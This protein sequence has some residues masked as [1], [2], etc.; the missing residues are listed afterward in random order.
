MPACDAVI[1]AYSGQ[2]NHNAGSRRANH[3]WQVLAR[4]PIQIPTRVRC[5]LEVSLEGGEDGHVKWIFH[6]TGLLIF[7]S[8]ASEPFVNH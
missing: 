8:A 2:A 1:T 3:V 7:T 5:V 6:S 4:A